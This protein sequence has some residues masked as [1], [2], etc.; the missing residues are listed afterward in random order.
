VNCTTSPVAAAD[1][2][3]SD[4][5]CEHFVTMTSVYN[6]TKISFPVKLNKEN[7][8]KINIKELIKYVW[9]CILIL[10]TNVCYN[11][12]YLLQLGC[13]PVAVVISH[14]TNI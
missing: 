9:E 8:S 11:N 1:T 4:S 12:I 10:I 3:V 5:Y 13:H 2:M 6:V 14:V 7:S